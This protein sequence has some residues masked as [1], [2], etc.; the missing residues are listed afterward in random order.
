MA[1]QVLIQEVVHLNTIG[2][3]PSDMLPDEA[4]KGEITKLLDRLE[5]MM[6]TVGTKAPI[7]SEL[8]S[9]S[10]ADLTVRCSRADEI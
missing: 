8:F 4:R 9:P 1:G 7:F 6:I 5:L 10:Q 2:A 3:Q